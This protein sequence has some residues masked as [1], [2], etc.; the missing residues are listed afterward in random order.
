MNLNNLV[1]SDVMAAKLGYH[2]QYLR[3]LARLEKIPAVKRGRAWLFDEVE[4]AKFLETQTKAAKKELK[5]NQY[6][7]RATDE[8]SDL[9][10]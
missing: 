3:D 7:R 6:G 8:G 5:E 10:Q 9:L 4:V 1:T 2:V